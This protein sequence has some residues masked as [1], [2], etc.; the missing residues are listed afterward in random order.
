VSSIAAK[1]TA[2]RIHLGQVSVFPVAA[3]VCFQQVP[4]AEPC[5]ALQRRRFSKPLIFW[6]VPIR[7]PTLLCSTQLGVTCH[8][9]PGANAPLCSAFPGNSVNGWLRTPGLTYFRPDPALPVPSA[10]CELS[11]HIPEYR[12][13]KMGQ[14]RQ[15]RVSH[16]LVFSRS[17]S[18]FRRT[19]GL[20]SVDATFSRV[21]MI[22]DRLFCP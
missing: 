1:P 10:G 4:R 12:R 11:A 19:S 2:E 9:T 16:C 3:A 20:A 13:K 6:M 22:S 17:R 5:G 15:P 8:P 7:Q 18:A 21:S 14:H